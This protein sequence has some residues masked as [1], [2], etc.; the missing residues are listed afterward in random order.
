MGSLAAMVRSASLCCQRSADVVVVSAVSGVTDLLLELHE[1]F[2]VNNETKSADLIER[3]KLKHQ[4]IHDIV[5]SSES[6]SRSIQVIYEELERDIKGGIKDFGPSSKDAIISYGERLSSAYFHIVL[7]ALSRHRKI[8]HIDARELI[9]TDSTY[10]S[11][12]PQIEEIKRNVTAKLSLHKE[13]VWLT[14]GFIGRDPQGITTTLGRGGSDYTAALLAEAL[15]ASTLEIWTDVSGVYD[16]DPFKNSNAKRFDQLKYD[17]ALRLAMHGAKV[18]HPGTIFPTKRA[19]IPVYV[20]NTFH[21][22]HGGTVIR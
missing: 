8:L 17:E 12:I 19:N 9:T 11:A 20:A 5:V 1:A 2:I 6:E 4:E 18:I 10:G 7:R 22:E 15:G 3:I 13:V 16:S 14:Q 21:P